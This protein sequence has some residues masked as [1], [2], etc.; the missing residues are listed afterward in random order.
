[1]KTTVKARIFAAAMPIL[2]VM[3]SLS[4]QAQE[5]FTK[6]HLRAAQQTI[7]AARAAEGFDDILP[8]MSEQTK[9]LFIRSNPALTVEIEDAAN[10]IALQMA[11]RRPELDRI[12]QEIW[13]RRFS[14]DELNQITAFYSTPVGKKLANDSAS[15]IALSVGAAKQWG[16]SLATEMVTQVR[17]ELKKQGHNL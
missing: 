2:L 7:K 17:E 4:V 3:G 12:I 10:K 13:A 1:M 5:E 16:D 9:S 8:V 6:E 15:I 11:A 14:E